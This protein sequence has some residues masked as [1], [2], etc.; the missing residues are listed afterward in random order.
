MKANLYN[1]LNS[2]NS[3]P[4]TWNS[5]RTLFSLQH[6][7]EER[8]PVQHCTASHDMVLPLGLARRTALAWNYSKVLEVSQ[9]SDLSCFLLDRCSLG[10]EPWPKQT[11]WMGWG[12]HCVLGKLELSSFG[13]YWT[14]A[15]L[16]P[17]FWQHV[18]VSP[19]LTHIPSPGA[20]GGFHNWFN[21]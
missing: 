17:L 1:W 10:W 21:L 14:H 8:G 20:V 3:S 18:P 19:F 6:Q 2:L 5:L 11:L 12:D 7:W 15:V 9:S 16:T 4:L 13:G